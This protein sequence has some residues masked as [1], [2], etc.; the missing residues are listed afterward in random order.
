MDHQCAIARRHTP[1]LYSEGE[2]DTL[3][4]GGQS[5]RIGRERGH[6]GRKGEI[7]EEVNSGEKRKKNMGNQLYNMQ[8]AY[9]FLRLMRGFDAEDVEVIRKAVE[10]GGI[11]SKVSKNKS[12]NNTD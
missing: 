12:R 11:D 1:T 6:T 9:R 5:Q 10:S 2:G 8:C 4:D 7:M 3:K